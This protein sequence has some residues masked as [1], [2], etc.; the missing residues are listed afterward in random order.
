MLK[1]IN[2]FKR[3]F[4]R[5]KSCFYVGATDILP[6]PLSVDEE[7]KYILLKDNGD[8]LA[9]E[10]L[11]EHNLRLVVFLAKTILQ[12]LVIAKMADNMYPFIKNNVQERKPI[13]R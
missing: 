13:R 9:K 1:I 10:K 12:N 11:I 4:V 2:L 3:L 7:E 6:E 8:N 5:V